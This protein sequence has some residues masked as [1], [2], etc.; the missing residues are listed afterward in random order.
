M[1]EGMVRFYGDTTLTNLVSGVSYLRTTDNTLWYGSSNSIPVKVGDAA[2]SNNV[3][4]SITNG[5]VSGLTTNMGF[6]NLSTNACTMYITN[7]LIKGVT[8]P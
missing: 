5:L 6:L 1:P 3:T 8:T 4:A 7:G 2:W